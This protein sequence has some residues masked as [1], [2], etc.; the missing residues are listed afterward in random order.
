MRWTEQR[1]FQA[2]LD[3]MADGRLD[4]APLISHRFPFDQAPQAY[5]TLT[6]SREALGILLQY[7]IGAESAGSRVALRASGLTPPGRW[8]VSSA[9]EITLHVF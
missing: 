8:S 6:G 9:L 1:N 4:V 3:M 7:D 5:R 2:V